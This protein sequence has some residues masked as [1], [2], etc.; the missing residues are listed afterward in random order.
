[1]VGFFEGLF[2]FLWRVVRRRED[3]KGER[4]DADTLRDMLQNFPKPK[5][6]FAT[7]KGK[8]IGVDDDEV[9]RILRG[10]GAVS[11]TSSE[12]E[13]LWG[14]KSRNPTATSTDGP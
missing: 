4:K 10:I 11:F 7:L 1:M 13:E 9:R 2:D 14:L 6:K 12:G 5:R 8:V 3:T